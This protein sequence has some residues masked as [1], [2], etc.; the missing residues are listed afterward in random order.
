[1]LVLICSSTPQDKDMLQFIFKGFVKTK[2]AKAIA[3]A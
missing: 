2:K 1:M 3:S